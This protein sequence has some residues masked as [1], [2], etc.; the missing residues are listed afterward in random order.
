M[1]YLYM[2]L[3]QKQQLL[4]A[5]NYLAFLANS[6]TPIYTYYTTEEFMIELLDGKKIKG[7]DSCIKH[8]E[9]TCGVKDLVMKAERFAQISP[10]FDIRTVCTDWTDVGFVVP[11]ATSPTEGYE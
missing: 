11:T 3:K 4:P 6:V 2:P 10:H 1:Y 8:F 7:L 5:L 9:T